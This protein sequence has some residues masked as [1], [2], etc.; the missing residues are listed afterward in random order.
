MKI[1]YVETYSEARRNRREKYLSQ[2]PVEM[3]LEALVEASMGRTEKLDSMIKKIKDIKR[4]HPYPSGKD[5]NTPKE[6][7]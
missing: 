2:Y 1:N 5:K 7:Q 6:A 3:Q 4:K